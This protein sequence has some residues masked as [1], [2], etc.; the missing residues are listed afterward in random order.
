MA[1]LDKFQERV[2]R[3]QDPRLR[4]NLKKIFGTEVTNQTLRELIAGRAIELIEERTAQGKD[5]FGSRMKAYS[6]TYK[7]SLDFKAFGK[8]NTVNL[9]LT[10]DM[11][12]ALDKL[13]STESK[14][15]LGFVDPDEGAKAHGHITGDGNLPQ[16]DFFGLTEKEIKSLRS[17]FSDQIDTVESVSALRVLQLIERIRGE[18]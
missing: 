6:K 7:N 18:G 2:L 1:K 15:E 16:R 8:S 9:V 13:E 4:L 11:F 3:G 5:R 12:N 17:E 10:G 14:I